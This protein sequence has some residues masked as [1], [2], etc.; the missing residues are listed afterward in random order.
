MARYSVKNEIAKV[1]DYL[2]NLYNNNSKY[3]ET[4]F[5]EETKKVAI[6]LDHIYNGKTFEKA[7]KEYENEEQ[8]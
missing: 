7:V 5:E 8:E 6:I 2:W 1:S 4:E 3:G